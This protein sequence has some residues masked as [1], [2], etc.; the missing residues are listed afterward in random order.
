[1]TWDIDRVLLYIP[2]LDFPIYWYGFLFALG[3][4][5]SQRWLVKDLIESKIATFQKSQ[6]L[7]FILIVSIIAG[8]RLGDV[9]FYQDL[10][11]VCKHPLDLFNLRAGGLSSHGGFAGFLIGL[12]LSCRHLLLSYYELLAKMAAP[13]G[14]LAFFIRLGNFFNQE[15]LGK[16][17]DG[18]LA[19]IFTRPLD[20]SLPMPRH[21]VVIYEA[22]GYLAIALYLKFS[23]HTPK[24]VVGLAMILYF[25][26]RLILEQ[27]KEE[28]SIHSFPYG[29]TMGMV[30]SLPII[31]TGLYICLSSKIRD[32]R[33]FNQSI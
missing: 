33:D 9:L 18:P 3:L 29:I 5:L 28:Q 13:A 10:F 32:T 27:F 14:L 22:L 2:F 15:I 7:I 19:V 23:K 30:L 25:G 26:S 12:Y 6:N 20:G 17:Y 8:A 24:R 11:Y 16:L 21:P 31:I 1:M 4:Y